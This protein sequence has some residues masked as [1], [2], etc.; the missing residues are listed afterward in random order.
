VTA[1]GDP[2]IRPITIR[3]KSPMFVSID[4]VTAPDVANECLQVLLPDIEDNMSLSIRDD[5]NEEALLT[6]PARKEITLQLR[7]APA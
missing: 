2:V 3:N 7:F 1:L 5:S 6:L 4:R